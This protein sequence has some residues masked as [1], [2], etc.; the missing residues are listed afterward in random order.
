MSKSRHMQFRRQHAWLYRSLPRHRQQNADEGNDSVSDTD[1][2][3]SSASAR[4]EFSARQNKHQ[5][6]IS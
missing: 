5:E 6:D 4:I 3:L 1:V 2:L